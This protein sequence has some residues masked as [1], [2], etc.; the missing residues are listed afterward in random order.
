MR[1]RLAA[2][3]LGE[4]AGAAIAE[5]NQS[6]RGLGGRTRR[7]ALEPLPLFWGDENRFEFCSVVLGS[8]EPSIVLAQIAIAARSSQIAVK[9]NE[10]FVAMRAEF[11][12]SSSGGGSQSDRRSKEAWPINT[13]GTRSKASIPPA[14]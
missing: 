6:S 14:N 7:D 1:R 10:Q 11:A 4:L 12:Q 5:L 2:T 3:P 9:A 8:N 13:L